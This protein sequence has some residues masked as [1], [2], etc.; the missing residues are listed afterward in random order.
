MI[1]VN[2]QQ[3]MQNASFIRKMFEEGE[4][5]RKLYGNDKVFDFSL[6]NPDYE[7]PEE[8]IDSLK[9]YI[10][11][12]IKGIH[13]YMSNS[14]HEDVRISI[15]NAVNKDSG[16]NL[17]QSNIIMTCGAAGGLNVVLKTILNPHDE[18]IVFAPYFSEYNFYVTNHGGKVVVSK[19]NLDTFE[20]DIKAL[21]NL[22]TS[23]C[24]GIIINSP[25]NPTGAVYSREILLKLKDLLLEKEKEFG[26]NILVISDEP[27]NKLIYDDIVVPNILSIFKNSVI[28]N[29]Y[30]K[31]LALPGERIGYI[32]VHPDCHSSDL[33]ING[34]IF[35]NR[36]LG[37]VNAP[38]L[39]QK[40][41][42]DCQNISIKTDAYKK[43][44]DFF[45]KSLIDCGYKCL[46]PKGA[47]YL[48]PKAPID[49]DIAFVNEALKHNLL[50]VPGS[51]FGCPGYF[52]IAYCTSIEIIENS[53][54]AFKQLADQFG[55]K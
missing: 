1:S 54:P 10:N 25:N 23:K 15:A 49:D 37:F 19:C 28:V 44:R 31:S 47:F 42:A 20:P 18:I 33:L 12:D 26:T 52:R 21:S 46:K 17:K 13:K 5:L 4:R 6:G 53:I 3:N 32:A 27:Y 41:V 35:A 14:G 39:F 24:K 55:Q 43:R 50:I 11:D 7:P 38:S 34:M 29:S 48:F 22:I 30:S 51:G 16:L 45:H 40:V 2:I 36:T 9:K 8:V